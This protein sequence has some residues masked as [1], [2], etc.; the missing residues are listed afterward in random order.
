MGLMPSLIDVLVPTYRRKTGLAMVLASL[1]GQTCRDFD[2][3]VSDQTPEDEEYLSSPEIRTAVAALEWHGHGVTLHRHVPRRGLAEHRDFLLSCS[4]ARYVHFLYDDVLLAPRVLERMATVLRE[5]QCG[6]VG[7]AAVGMDFLGDERP[8]QQQIEL[9]EG[10]VEPEPFAGEAIPWNRH[11]VN[12]AANPQHLERKLVRNGE[13][14]RYKVAWVG[15]ANVL[16]D[17]EKLLSVGGFGWWKKLPPEH[18]GEE[19]LAQLLLLRKYGGCGV[20]PSGTYHMGLPTTIS[21]RSR[22]AT[23][24]LGELMASDQSVPELSRA[25]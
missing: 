2:V 3:I 11:V 18:A 14:V 6:F 20:L 24:L 1:L 10:R 17:R 22:N 15:G 19:V 5:E 12:N 25:S 16:F 4:S 13:T 23:E 9:W 7:A 21:D 8:H